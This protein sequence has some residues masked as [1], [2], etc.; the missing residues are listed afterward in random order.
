[1]R[2]FVVGYG[3]VARSFIDLLEA[4][5]SVLYQQQGLSPRLVGVCDSTG[6]AVSE[7]G[8]SADELRAAKES[9]GTVA[10]VAGHGVRT[11]DAAQLIAEC[12]ADI[13][14]EASPSQMSTPGRSIENLKAAFRTG[15]HAISVNKAPLAAAMPAMLELAEFNGVQFRF[16]GTVGGGT[17]VL[18]VAR[19]CARGDEVTMVRGIFNGTTNFILWKMHSEGLDFD[20]VLKEAIDLGY[21][22]TDPSAD[23]D[24]VDAATKV[25]ILANYVL[26]RPATIGD[27]KVEGIRGLPRERIE[28]AAQRGNHLKLIGEIGEALSVAP[29]EVPIGDPLDVPASLNAITLSLKASSDITLI[30]RGAGGIETATSVMRDLLDIWNVI[31]GRS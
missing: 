8:L 10:G 27:V 14:V 12:D 29:Q 13:V 6:A 24:G 5:Q 30:G 4:Q 3:V 11:V 15:K 28:E 23:I 7:R 19:E 31:G 26:G 2:I 18:N 9:T 25:V 22:E 16:S 1:M 17:P 20:T 21:A